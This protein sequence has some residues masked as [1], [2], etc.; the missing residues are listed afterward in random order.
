MKLT[1][2]DFETK[3]ALKEMMKSTVKVEVTDAR[4]ERSL[5]NINFG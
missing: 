3:E 1:K 2:I 4:M 5:L